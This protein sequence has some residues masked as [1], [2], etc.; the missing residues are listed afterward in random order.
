MC[1]VCRV[2]EWR[3]FSP[4]TK[5]MPFV[6]FDLSPSWKG[7]NEISTIWKRRARK[8][9]VWKGVKKKLYIRIYTCIYC[10][11]ITIDTGIFFRTSRIAADSSGHSPARPYPPCVINTVTN[12]RERKKKKNTKINL[13]YFATTRVRLVLFRRLFFYFRRGFFPPCFR[14]SSVAQIVPRSPLFLFSSSPHRPV[15]VHIVASVCVFY[16]FIF[17][18]LAHGFQFWRTTR[19]LDPIVI[20]SCWLGIFD[21]I[22][23]IMHTHV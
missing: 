21:D 13:N 7:K 20:G 10:Y 22:I 6:F 23:I 2:G 18:L 8:S 14:R 11:F 17:F 19:A 1:T 5:L 16:L 12:G 4:T 9:I 3:R 15:V